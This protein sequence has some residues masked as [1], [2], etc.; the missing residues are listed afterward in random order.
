MTSIKSKTEYLHVEVDDVLGVHKVDALA[1]L[2]Q[3]YRASL[4]CEHKV[5]VYHTLE[6][7]TAFDPAI[8]QTRGMPSADEGKRIR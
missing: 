4:L 1:N 2:A 6:Q 8:K 7:F 5:V 3:E